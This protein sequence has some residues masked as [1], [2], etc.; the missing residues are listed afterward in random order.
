MPAR[1]GPCTR[2]TTRGSRTC[3]AGTPWSTSTPSSWARCA[4][5]SGRVPA[6]VRLEPARRRPVELHGLLLLS[7]AHVED[8]DQQG[9]GHREVDVALAHVLPRALGDEH[10]ADQEQEAEGE[11]LHAGVAIDE[12]AHGAREDEHHADREHHRGGHH[13]ELL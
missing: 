11:D 10:H 1:W 8:F 12:V 13:R 6:L 5:A 9:E 7:K 3:T 2:S 4:G